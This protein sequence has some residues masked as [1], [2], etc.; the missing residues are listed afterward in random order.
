M[1]VVLIAICAFVDLLMVEKMITKGKQYVRIGCEQN[2]KLWTIHTV[3]GMLS[4]MVYLA[5]FPTSWSF[6]QKDLARGVYIGIFILLF[7]IVEFISPS[8]QLLFFFR[9]SPEQDSEQMHEIEESYDRFYQFLVKIVLSL[10]VVLGALQLGIWILAKQWKQIERQSVDN[11][12]Q[13]LLYGVGVF[14]VLCVSIS[15]RQMIT[16]LCLTKKGYFRQDIFQN[17]RKKDAIQ[18]RLRARHRK[19]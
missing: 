12:E 13:C 14:L 6:Q 19:L 10:I 9:K 11:V 15:V 5:A 2:M 8:R 7:L 1:N 16:Q 18:E 17:L 4:L 3:I